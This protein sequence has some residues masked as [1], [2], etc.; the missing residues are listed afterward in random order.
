M[1]QNPEVADAM[2]KALGL[3]DDQIKKARNGLQEKGLIDE[4]GQMTE[5]GIQ[6]AKAMG[7]IPDNS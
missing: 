7:L 6:V 5:L 2:C 4:N 1:K 3:S